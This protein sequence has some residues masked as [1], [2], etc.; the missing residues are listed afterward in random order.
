MMH[1]GIFIAY[2]FVSGRYLYIL[3]SNFI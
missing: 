3:Q 2:I 1:V